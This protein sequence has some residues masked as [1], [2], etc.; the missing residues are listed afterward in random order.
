MNTIFLSRLAHLS[1]PDQ[2]Q[3]S[4]LV[5]ST[6]LAIAMLAL[7]PTAAT[8][9]LTLAG[10]QAYLEASPAARYGSAVAIGDFNGDGLGDM[11]VGL[12]SQVAGAFPDHGAVALYL[13]DPTEGYT[14]TL[15]TSCAADGDLGAD[16]RF[17]SSL[18]FGHFNDDSYDDLAVGMPGAS[19]GAVLNAGAVC[20]IYGGPLAPP[21][22]R[23][24]QSNLQNFAENGDQFGVAIHAGDLNGDGLD[25]LVIG[26][27]QESINDEGIE[28]ANAGALHVVTGDA[29][30]LGVAGNVFRSKDNIGAFGITAAANE[31]FGTSFAI[32]NFSAFTATNELAVGAPGETGGGTV[33]V[34]S[35]QTGIIAQ[36]DAPISVSSPHYDLLGTG[37]DGDV[38]GFSL[39]AGDFNGDG[40][41]DL[42]IGIPGD[43]DLAVQPGAG[44]V[45]VLYGDWVSLDDSNEQVFY[46]SIL[47]GGALGVNMFDH[48]GQV[49]S[50]G[51]FNA[52]GYADLAIGAPFDDS[53]G[54][55][56]SGEV[57]VLYGSATGLSF[58]G[59]QL[60]G[61]IFFG[62]LDQ[63]DHFG[64]ALA[65]GKLFANTGGDDLVIGVPGRI[66]DFTRGLNTPNTGLVI[67]VQ[68]AVLFADGFESGNVSAWQ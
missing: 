58:A 62:S 28:L 37:V 18:A 65:T 2:C 25:E 67:A 45:M 7:C 6:V 44:A 15:I 63:N 50:A 34:F 41:D 11:A 49:L 43:D 14:T 54:V 61:M 52:D 23:F 16:F 12:P 24:D 19:V 1:R 57:T 8:S 9:Q 17:G 47:D 35:S 29:S 66:Y 68:S 39:A 38:F 3:L 20:V 10:W 60:L 22:Q 42:A 21:S 48:F 36:I 13:S 56:N 30:G 59:V 4:R 26:A 32:G 27:P 40:T 55:L 64:S 46:E 33:L 51:D 53:L 5:A 31:F